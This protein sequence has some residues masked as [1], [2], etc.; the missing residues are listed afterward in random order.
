MWRGGESERGDRYTWAGKIESAE[1]ATGAE[2]AGM[3]REGARKGQVPRGRQGQDKRAWGGELVRK[4]AMRA[5]V[6][7]W[8]WA[9]RSMAVRQSDGSGT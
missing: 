8:G 3:G 2:R 4:G 5:G 9:P 1:E 6:R 7:A